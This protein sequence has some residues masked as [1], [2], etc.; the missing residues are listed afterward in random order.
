MAANLVPASPERQ[1]RAERNTRVA[2]SQASENLSGSSTFPTQ[3]V[4][5]SPAT[6]LTRGT[7]ALAAPTARAYLEG[8]QIPA[9]RFPHVDDSTALGFRGRSLSSSPRARSPA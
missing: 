8:A 4:T 2:R 9:F 7:L 3:A 1:R 5:A 6:P